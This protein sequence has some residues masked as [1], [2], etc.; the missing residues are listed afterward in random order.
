MLRPDPQMYMRM[1]LRL[2]RRGEGNISPNPMVGAVIVKNGK[3]VGK[4]YHKYF[5]G[6]HAEV[7]AIK[8]AGV[9]AKGATLFVTLEPCSHFGKTPP[10]TQAIIK[11]GIKKVVAATFD[12]NPLNRGKAFEILKE[13]GIDTEVGVLEEEAKKVNQYFFKYISTK[14]PYVTVKA[15][16]SLDGKIAT[17]KGESKWITS[18]RSRRWGKKLRDKVDAILVGINTVMKDDPELLPL[19]N[20]KRYLR[21]VLDTH[22][23]IPL[24]AKILEQQS[25][26][27]TLIFT[28]SHTGI[29]KMKVLTEKGVGVKIVEEKEGRVNLGKVLQELGKMEIASLLVEGG[30]EVIASFIKENQVDELFLFLSPCIIGGKEA[31]TWVEGEGFCLLKDATKVKI[32]SIRRVGED[33]LLRGKVLSI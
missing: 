5:G 30:G 12:P 21:V 4:G 17:F 16:T 29:D 18:E 24:G 26:F 23:K 11:A 33:V 28:G 2:A 27:P 31:P 8:N 22:L 25:N 32:E 3:V 20:K 7:E 15:A 10:C 14:I 6:P 19:K 1:A 13:A 9:K